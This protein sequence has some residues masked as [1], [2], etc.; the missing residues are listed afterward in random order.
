MAYESLTDEERRPVFRIPFADGHSVVIVGR[1]FPDDPGTEYFVSH[2]E[3]DRH[4]YLVLDDSQH[5][6][7]PVAWRRS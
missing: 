4:G 2:P 6:E 1:N 3:W 5:E 7:E